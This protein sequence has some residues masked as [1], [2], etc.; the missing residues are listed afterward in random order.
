MKEIKTD[1]NKKYKFISDGTWF[2][3]GTEC[4]VEDGNCLWYHD[5]NKEGEIPYDDMISIP[6]SISGIFQG[7]R[8]CENP[9]SEGKFHA[10]G[11]E[12]EDGEVCC[13][14]EFKIIKKEL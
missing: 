1:Y 9:L 12:Y 7:L 3:K 6:D 2:K 4:I 5:R 13:L 14:D 8:I 10:I 11:E